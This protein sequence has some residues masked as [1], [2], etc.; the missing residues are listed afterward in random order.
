MK[1]H[2]PDDALDRALFAL[3]LEE[4]PANLRAQILSATIYRA[5]SAVKSWEPWAIGVALAVFTWLI[6]W[7]AFDSAQVSKTLD[8]AG[9]A[10]LGFFSQSATLLWIA[11]GGA[12]A[13]WYSQATLLRLP[14]RRR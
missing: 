1:H 8:L 6:A 5:P 14:V 4:P 10:M 12:V 13:I 11:L 2:D 9:S 3:P 7:T